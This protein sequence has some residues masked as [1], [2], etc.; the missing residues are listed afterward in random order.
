MGAAALSGA[1][2]KSTGAYRRLT[3]SC[4]LTPQRASSQQPS[5]RV[6]W[7]VRRARGPLSRV[8]CRRFN[9]VL[10]VRWVYI[11][12]SQLYAST[13]P[14]TTMLC[15]GRARCK[16]APAC[17]TLGEV[18][19]NVKGSGAARRACQQLVQPRAVIAF[20]CIAIDNQ[21]QLKWTSQWRMRTLSSPPLAFIPQPE[22]AR[23]RYYRH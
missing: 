19:G 15:Y 3:T 5:A 9:D 11:T 13:M 16:A 7:R 18:L 10:L 2:F 8:T 6:S 20:N 22:A 23:R 21:Q 12:P 1:A 4:I 14:A 17:G